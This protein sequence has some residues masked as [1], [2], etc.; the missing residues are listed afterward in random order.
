[1]RVSGVCQAAASAAAIVLEP[2]AGSGPREV[3][4][5]GHVAAQGLDLLEL[6][7]RLDTL[8]HGRRRRWRAREAITAETMADFTG[9]WSMSRTK[10]WSI[11]MT[12][13]GKWAR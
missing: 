11:L 12:S 10:L 1:M 7:Q 4:A 3:E 13:M 5:L 9:S 8:D 6:G 2:S